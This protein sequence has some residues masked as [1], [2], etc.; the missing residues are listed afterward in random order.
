MHPYPILNS[1]LYAVNLIMIFLHFLLLSTSTTGQSQVWFGVEYDPDYQPVT[2]LLPDR[3]HGIKSADRPASVNLRPF[4]PVPT[5]QGASTAC[6]GYAT[7]YGAMTIM[8]AV[9][10]GRT[11]PVSFWDCFSPTFVYN[12][13][14]GDSS[15]CGSGGSPIDTAIQLLC[16]RGICRNRFFDSRSDCMLQPGSGALEAALPYRIREGVLL[17]KGKVPESQKIGLIRAALADSV[18]VIVSIQVYEGFRNA[19]GKTWRKSNS[20]T[21]NK[22]LGDHALVVTGYNDSLRTFQLMNSWGTS[23]AD[24]GFIQVIYED[25]AKF[26][27]EAYRLYLYDQPEASDALS[28]AG[29]NTT[30]A[31]LGKSSAFTIR[32]SFE[33]IR[34]DQDTAR[35]VEV[36]YNKSLKCYESASEAFYTGDLFQMKVTKVPAGKCVYL[37]SC[38]PQG[39]V[40]LHWPES[41]EDPGISQLIPGDR[42]VLWLPDED[43]ALRLTQTGTE[44]WCVLY[45]EERIPDIRERLARIRDYSAGNFEAVFQKAFGDLLISEDQI[46]IARSNMSIQTKNA[47]LSGIAIPL[48]LKLEILSP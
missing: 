26:C 1:K 22:Y 16:N 27:L 6:V 36:R 38:D 35:Y 24:G 10:S 23:W 28:Y 33:L 20:T 48:I 17:F 29:G 19:I 42:S 3:Y 14:H 8:E 31:G 13:I 46:N 44:Y 12:Q 40:A 4:C 9:S 2:P 11:S 37:F 41:P 18:P 39:K 7:G 34:W 43:D 32:G 30:Q 25:F 21:D 15:N 5:S 47:H 45:A